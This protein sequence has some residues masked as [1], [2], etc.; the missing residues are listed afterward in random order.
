MG[1]GYLEKSEY[2]KKGVGGVLGG[3]L[4]GRNRSG[5]GGKSEWGWREIGVGVEGEI[6]VGVEGNRSPMGGWWGFVGGWW[7]FVGG[8]WG[9]GVGFGGLVGGWWGVGVVFGGL[10]GG[11]RH[12]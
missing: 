5:G 3:V 10:G 8:W 11:G 2:T 12:L 6:G 1:G 9:F 4:G 7:E